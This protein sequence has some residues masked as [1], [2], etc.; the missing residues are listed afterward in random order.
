MKKLTDRMVMAQA[1]DAA[2]FLVFYLFIAQGSIHAERNPLILALMA[3]GGLQLVG[4]V[5][6]GLAL[7]VRHRALKPRVVSRPY[8]AVRFTMLTLAT[9]SGITGAGFNI[10]SIVH[11]VT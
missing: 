9:A 8:A 2:T 6:V 11:S 5:K 10:A 7:V 3:L 1:I 4:L